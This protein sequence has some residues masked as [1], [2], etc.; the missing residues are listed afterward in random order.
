LRRAAFIAFIVVAALSASLLFWYTLRKD[1]PDIPADEL[2]LALR[3]RMDTCMSCHGPGEKN[4]R[5]RNH[6]VGTDC[7]RCHYW[8]GERR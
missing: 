5:G 6:P 8:E 1:R 2:H 3:D 7:L 4:D